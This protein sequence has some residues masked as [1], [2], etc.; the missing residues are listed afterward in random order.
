MIPT[1][2]AL[3]QQAA[4]PPAGPAPTAG[5]GAGPMPGCAGGLG[6]LAPMLLIFVV[7]YFMLIRP[8]QKKQREL[9]DWLKSIKIGDEVVTTGGIIGKISGLKEDIVTLEVQEKVRMRILRSHI[10]GR[11]PGASPSKSSP[12]P[13]KAAKNDKSE[14]PEKAEKSEKSEKK[15]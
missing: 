4:P 6:N 14:K 9:Q 13:E 7:F 11:A 15:A 12:E 8:Q 2:F 3:I 5:G 10:A 1:H